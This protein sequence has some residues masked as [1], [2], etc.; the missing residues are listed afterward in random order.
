MKRYLAGLST[1]ALIALTSPTFAMPTVINGAG[2]SF[3]INAG[4]GDR[5]GE[6]SELSIT[7]DLAGNISWLLDPLGAGALDGANAV[8]IYIDTDN[9]ATGFA[10][11]TSFEDVGGGAD[12]LR[13]ATSAYNGVARTDLT[14]APGFLANYALAFNGGVGVAFELGAGGTGHTFIEVISDAPGGGGFGTGGPYN[15]THTMATLDLS[16]GDSFRYFAT[17]MNPEVVTANAGGPF[18]SNEYQGV[19]DS[20][21]P[22]FNTG[23]DPVSLSA[24]DFNTFN[25]VPEPAS[26]ALLVL[27]GLAVMGR[28][29]R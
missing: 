2:S 26:L 3:G 24:G 18:R 10:D 29:R 12:E 20:S 16:P 27:G 22:D 7:S 21:V 6:N 13:G 5:I 28:A 4:F 1:M 14:F 19:A 9:G 15:F 8:V 23:F 11:T 17:Y 25:S